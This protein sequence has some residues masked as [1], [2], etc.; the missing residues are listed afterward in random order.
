MDSRGVR[1]SKMWPD[2][3]VAKTCCSQITEAFGA[4]VSPWY[5]YRF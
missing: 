5:L 3:L 2:L 1:D 4:P